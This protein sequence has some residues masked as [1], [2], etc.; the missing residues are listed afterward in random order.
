MQLGE[1]QHEQ[2][3]LQSMDRYVGGMQ[4][5]MYGCSHAFWARGAATMGCL[6]MRSADMWSVRMGMDPWQ[7]EG[8]GEDGSVLGSVLDG[9]GLRYLKVLKVPSGIWKADHLAMDSTL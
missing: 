4:T 1:K 6:R 3:L 8:R 9:Q 7:M 2:Q 5:T